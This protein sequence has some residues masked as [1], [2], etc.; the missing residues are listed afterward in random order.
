MSAQ[1]FTPS[2][3]GGFGAGQILRLGFSR[4]GYEVR[5][6]FRQADS[7]FFTFLFPLVLLLIFSLAFSTTTFGD[8]SAAAYYLPAM[9]AAG[10]LLM[11]VQNLA[12]DI[13]VERGD[14]T[15]KR[16]GGTPLSPV[17]YFIG[18]LGTVLI[19]G[20]AQAALLVLVAVV[21]FGVALPSSPERWLTFAWVFVLG[22]TTCAILGIGL[23]SLPRSGRSATAVIL[24]IVLVL[25]F[26]SGVFI[27]FSSLPGWL[28]TVAGIFPLRWLVQGMQSVFLPDSFASTTPSGTWEHGLILLVTGLWLVGGL[29]LARLTFRWIRKDG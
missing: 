15:L 10:L 2:R 17:S 27:P 6:Y 19:A 16:L 11:G 3:T 8:L 1:T 12:I 7:V 9:L 22:V 18:K 26:I 20:L 14:G 13:A 21:A 24:P 28:Q 23:S 4:I 29:V 25:Q 5:S